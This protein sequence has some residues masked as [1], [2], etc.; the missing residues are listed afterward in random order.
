M[1]SDGAKLLQDDGMEA[2]GSR[3]AL[4]VEE[5]GSF[6]CVIQVALIAVRGGRRT[7]WCILWS[8]MEYGLVEQI[9]DS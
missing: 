5:T 6:T 2:G 9:L 3:Y 1:E 4:L 8:W 7:Q